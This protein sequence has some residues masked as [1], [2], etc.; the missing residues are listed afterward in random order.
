MTIYKNEKREVISVN[1]VKVFKFKKVKKLDK[2]KINLAYTAAISSIGMAYKMSLAP[3]DIA[4]ALYV[5]GEA[6]KTKKDCDYTS[7]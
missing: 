1:T 6:M 2:E 3:I 5:E 7:K 4:D